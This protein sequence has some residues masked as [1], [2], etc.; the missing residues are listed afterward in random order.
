[1]NYLCGPIPGP[2]MDL[3]PGSANVGCVDNCLYRCPGT[4]FICQGGNQKS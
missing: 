4:F 3:K 2:I 1:M